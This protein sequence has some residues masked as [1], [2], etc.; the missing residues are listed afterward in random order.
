MTA[1]EK[2]VISE[3]VKY[4]K[5]VGLNGHTG[6]REILKEVIEKTEKLLKK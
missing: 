4:S 3:L 1:K 5:A 2:E 6:V